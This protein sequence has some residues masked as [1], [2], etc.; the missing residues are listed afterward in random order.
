MRKDFNVKR[1]D[2][3]V[4]QHEYN[5]N[6]HDY[7]VTWHDYCAAHGTFCYWSFAQFAKE[8]VQAVVNPQPTLET[9]TNNTTCGDFYYI[10][11]LLNHLLQN[12]MSTTNARELGYLFLTSPVYI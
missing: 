8:K 6:Q 10:Q 1:H 11:A 12:K 9:N 5:V 7:N 4:K 3:N 2:Y